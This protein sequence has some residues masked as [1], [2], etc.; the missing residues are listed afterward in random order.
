M[1]CYADT[2]IHTQNDNF[3]SVQADNFICGADKSLPICQTV[4]TLNQRT[5]NSKSHLKDHFPLTSC[6]LPSSLPPFLPCA[7]LNCRCCSGH[8]L[9]VSRRLIVLCLPLP[10]PS[11]LP[12]PLPQLPLL[13]LLQLLQ[14]LQPPIPP[15]LPLPQLPLLQL[16]QR[17]PPLPPLPILV[18][19]IYTKLVA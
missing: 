18:F 4:G 11:P 17:L 19:H 5:R 12:L 7:H 14:L 16:L 9:L 8:C 15:P 13:P 10:L 3:L 1:F 2:Q 6:P